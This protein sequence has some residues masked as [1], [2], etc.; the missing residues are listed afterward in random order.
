MRRPVTELYQVYTTCF[1]SPHD[2]SENSFYWL[3]GVSLRRL[4]VVAYHAGARVQVP[5]ARMNGSSP[6]RVPSINSAPV[7]LS[8][9]LR[10]VAP[11]P[12]AIRRLP[13]EHAHEILH[14]FAGDS[15]SERS[16]GSYR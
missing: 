15:V 5:S 14:S 8:A 16:L 2:E 3:A 9:R 11:S 10:R 12:P 4:A 13:M 7:P 1:V 6:Y